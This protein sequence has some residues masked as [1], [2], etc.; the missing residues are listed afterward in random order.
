M[1]MGDLGQPAHNAAW[2]ENEVSTSVPKV[3]DNNKYKIPGWGEPFVVTM[4]VENDFWQDN[5]NFSSDRWGK[6]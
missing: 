2:K 5:V 3:G 4:I 1:I 6:E